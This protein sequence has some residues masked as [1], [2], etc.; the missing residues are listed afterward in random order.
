VT[1]FDLIALGV[2][3]VSALSG[4]AKGAVHE[5]IGLFAFTLS[6]LAAMAFLPATAPIARHFLHSGWM[7]TAA[8]VIVTFVIVF[9]FLRVLASTLTASV[10]RASVLGGANRFGGLVFG[11]LRGVV[12]LGLFALVFNRATPEEWKPHWITGGL[13]YPLA[14]ASGRALETVIPKGLRAA[15]GFRPSIGDAVNADSANPSAPAEE[16]RASEPPE[17]AA[18]RDAPSS[19]RAKPKDHGYTK[20][21]RD[22]V[23]AL[24][25][26]S[27]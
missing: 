11:G 27:K 14:S 24:V 21:A 3:A 23:D 13:F 15:D 22:S 12:L 19:E 16:D 10:N 17:S 5:L 18:R 4:F 20:H 8:A 1:L 25:E 26:R 6:G 7:S 9:V 2:I